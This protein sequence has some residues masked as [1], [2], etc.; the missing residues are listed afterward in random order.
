MQQSNKINMTLQKIR[1]TLSDAG[2]ENAAMEA[3]LLIEAYLDIPR[4]RLLANPRDTDYTDPRLIAAVKKR[5]ERFPLQYII[6]SWDFYG[7][8]FKVNESCLIP[9][10]DTEIVVEEALHRL[11]SDGKLLDLCT[12]SGCI[13]AAVLYYTKNTSAA[14][15]ELYPETAELARENMEN[16]G[17]SDR[18]EV[19]VGDA[20][21]DLFDESTKFD[22][23]TANPPYVTALE[24]CELEPELKFEPEH[25]LTDG[26]DGLAII[27]SIIEI[28]KKHL[29][30][31]GCMIIEHGWRQAEAVEKIAHENGLAY[32]KLIDYGG[33]AR[34]AVLTIATAS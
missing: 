5:S 32:T 20:K 14:A 30:A 2:I 34:A 9:R 13:A 3:E 25:A 12:G 26:G 18:C 11:K 16:L 27:R 28:Y 23:I 17:L 8:R 4:A 22:V 21:A 29:K 33:N 10:A 31:D 15:V 1:N 24:L 7:L 19:I 6:G